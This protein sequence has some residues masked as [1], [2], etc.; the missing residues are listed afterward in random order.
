MSV[1]SVAVMEW[2]IREL[3]THDKIVKQWGWDIDEIRDATMMRILEILVQDIDL[4]ELA[5]TVINQNN[6]WITH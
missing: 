6:N 4:T 3:E 5:I 2:I 1:P